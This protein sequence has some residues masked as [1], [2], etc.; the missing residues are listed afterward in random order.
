MFQP[1][2][3]IAAYKMAELMA[4]TPSM[5]YMRT[6]RPDAPFIY[7]FEAEFEV[8]G[9]TT[10][11]SGEAITVVASGIMVSEAQKACQTLARDSVECTLIDAYSLPLKADPILKSASR[12]HNMILTVEDNYGGGFGSA[13]AEAAAKAGRI[14]VEQ[15][16][17][18]RIPKSAYEPAQLMTE[19]GL[20]AS[21]IQSKIRQ[22]VNP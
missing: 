6:H 16:C 17:V 2:D 18:R 4:N 5:C 14:R 7:P 3:G 21:A 15:L 1:A 8:G 22:L 19:H 12:T 9:C 11:H 10:L 13:V 20:S